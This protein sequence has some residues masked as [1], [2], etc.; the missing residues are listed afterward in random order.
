MRVRI[1][2]ACLLFVQC[3][4]ADVGAAVYVV[5]PEGSGDFP[6]IQ[7]AIDACIAGDVVAL[8]GGTFTGPGNRDIDFLG[9]AITVRSGSGNPADCRIDCEGNFYFPHRGFHFHSGEGES[10]RIESISITGGYAF[11]SGSYEYGGGGI[12]FEEESYPVIS[13]CIFVENYATYGGG[14]LSKTGSAPL[15]EDCAFLRNVGKGGAGILIFE[16]SSAILHDCQFTDNVAEEGGGGGGIL[17]Y[18]AMFEAIRCTFE[19]NHARGGGAVAFALSKAF[20]DQCTFQGNSAGMAGAVDADYGSTLRIRDC[21]FS[22]NNAEVTGGLFGYRTEGLDVLGC[23]FRNNTSYEGGS[24]AEFRECTV[25]VR[26]CVFENNLSDRDTGGLRLGSGT[27]DL[28]DCA[29]F[30]NEGS[31]IAA[32]HSEL[33]L[34]RCTFYGNTARTGAAIRATYTAPVITDCTIV[35]NH[36]ETGG[37]ALRLWGTSAEINWTLI[38]FNTGGEAVQYNQGALLQFS[39]CDIYGNEGG[40]WIG[41]FANQF[42]YYGN[43]S[44][45]PLFCDL[46]GGDLTLHRDSP[47]ARAPDMIHGAVGAHEIGCGNDRA[48][49]AE[50]P[51]VS[52]L[53]LA[54]CQPNPF[55]RST[56]LAFT[57][58]PTALV[59]PA[60]LMIH[61]PSGRRVREWQI[62]EAGTHALDW[63]GTDQQGIPV[64]GGVYF[65]RLAVGTQ[66]QIRP[67]TLLR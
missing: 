44:A 30:D 31:G 65:C 59:A 23:T 4:P 63:D 50:A 26:F 58:P 37:A 67:V 49:S 16:A 22:E 52:G 34:T 48:A 9:K 45:D 47:C 55:G 21:L 24:G 51:L 19:G 13:N 8:T 14:C 3:V 7:A 10:A 66:S 2:F 11:S 18:G 57:I 46:A 40:D 42:G 1:L 35:G 39:R 62:G 32:A 41:S 56:R 36:G 12:L 29:F 60:T 15:L 33:S 28:E 64:Q 17:A 38:A 25:N 5:N 20:I 54:P 27:A 61:D 6:T 43:V 53:K